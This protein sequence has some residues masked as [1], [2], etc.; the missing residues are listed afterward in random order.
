MTLKLVSGL[1][2]DSLSGGVVASI[3][4]VFPFVPMGLPSK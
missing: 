4:H 3:S 2:V 1:A